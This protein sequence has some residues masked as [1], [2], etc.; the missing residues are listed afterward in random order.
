MKKILIGLV[1]FAITLPAIADT[2]F[3]GG[4][5]LGTTD[6][7]SKSS[8]SSTFFGEE[9]NEKFKFS[10]DSTSYSIR[11]GYRFHEYFSVELGHYEYG[12]VTYAYIDDFDDSINDK[13]NTNSNNLGIKAIWPITE[14]ISLN[15]SVSIAKWNF[16]VNS[17]DSS[18][19]DEVIEVSE[20]G[21][22][23]YYGTGFEYIINNRV[24]IGLE[25][26]S[27]AMKWD[28]SESANDF[29]FQSDIEHKVNNLSLT[30]QMK[31]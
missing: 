27:L 16:D 3:Y 18:I 8:S 11:G 21:I 1:A 26:S 13:I 25:Y 10:G 24:S 28:S 20:D 5:S 2:G 22:D 29:S 30:V 23:I 12:K 7:Q 31:F 9:F 15:V 4:V 17:T 6:N 19:P 14:F